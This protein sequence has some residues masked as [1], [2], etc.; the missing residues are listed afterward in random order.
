MNHIRYQQVMQERDTQLDKEV[1]KR[2]AEEKATGFGEKV[3]FSRYVSH[4]SLKHWVLVIKGKKYELRRVPDG[5]YTYNVADWTIDDEK[6]NAALAETKM[7]KVDSYYVCLIGW[8]TVPADR[9]EAIAKEIMDQF[10]SYSL[11]WNNCQELVDG[12]VVLM[13]APSGTDPLDDTDVTSTPNHIFGRN[14][15]GLTGGDTVILQGGSGSHVDTGVWGF[16]N[17]TLA[18]LAAGDYSV[19]AYLTQYEK[20]TRSDGSTVNVRFPC[21]DGQPNVNAPGSLITPVTD[22]TLTGDSQTVNLTFTNITAAEVFTGKEIGGC[23]QGN[24]EDQDLLKYVKIRSEALSR[25][26]NRDM[27]VGATVLVPHDYFEPA[28][29]HKRYPVIYDQDHWSADDGGYYY[30]SSSSFKKAWDSGTVSG[31]RTVPEFIIIKFRHEAPFYDDS[32]AVNTPNLGPWGEAINDELVPYLDTLFRTIA[33]PYARIQDGGSTGGWESIATTIFRPDLYGACFSYYPDSLDFRKHQDIELYT[34]KNAYIRENGSRVPSIRQFSNSGTEVVLASTEQ[35]NHWELTFGTQTRSAGQWDIWNAVFGI[36]G[37]NGYPLEPWDKVT[38]EIYPESVSYWREMDLSYYVGENWE[39]ERQL[40]EALRD[41]LH[42]SVGTWDN[43]YLNEGVA[44]FQSRVEE[45]GG[46]DWANITILPDKTHGGYYLGLSLWDYL[47]IVE[48]WIS[49]HAP[50]GT[51]PLSS[52]ATSKARS[53]N[54]FDGVMRRGG[55]QA[56]LDR[57]SPPVIEKKSN[58]TI[59]AT[60]GRWDPGVKLTGRWVANGGAKGKSFPVSRGQEVVYD[61]SHAQNLNA[62]SLEVTGEKYGYE[63]ET[64]SSQTFRA[65]SLL[66]SERRLDVNAADVDASSDQPPPRHADML[67][68]APPGRGAV[69]DGG[70]SRGGAI[71]T[72][73]TRFVARNYQGRGP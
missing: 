55:R 46:P 48:Q 69:R 35:E 51:Q 24:Y 21:G 41:R 62:L 26:W 18:E 39:G 30:T 12:R 60:V 23:R 57:Q 6:R 28:N 73:G 33:K 47:D 7:P 45:L 64:R 37:L 13:F 63:T 4:G 11:L 67:R 16:P 9:L 32:Y 27:Y 54:D 31:N 42:V 50:N 22:V 70:C 40:G 3:W 68:V 15:L 8:T 56:A 1:K 14:V 43:Y 58:S 65:L 34:A 71:P 53:G 19:Q 72:S 20:V 29:Q 66:T 2:Q 36:Q 5:N 38:G 59:T 25:F 17:I 49:D 61:G 44:M 52:F 10:G